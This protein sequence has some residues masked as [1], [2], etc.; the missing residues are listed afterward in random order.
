MDQVVALLWMMIPLSQDGEM[1]SL[2]AL[3]GTRANL[4]GRL[5]MLIEEVLLQ[6]MLMLTTFFQEVKTAL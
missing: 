6:Y 3:I 2:D 5:Q 4:S 1:V